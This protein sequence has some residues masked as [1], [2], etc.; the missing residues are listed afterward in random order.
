MVSDINKETVDMVRNFDDTTDEP[1]VLPSKFPF[2][3]CNGTTGI[4]VGMATNMPPHNLREVASAISAYIDN[5]DISTDELMRHIKGPDFPTGGVIYG[6]AG[7]KKA[8]LTGRGKVTIRSKFKIETDK[9]GNR[10]FTP[11]AL[12]LLC[13]S[14]QML[15][16]VSLL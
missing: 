14:N 2:L 8:Y 9:N 10:F 16:L 3:L 6:T 1:S 13:G 12:A 5:N 7:I 4:A 11:S 15:V